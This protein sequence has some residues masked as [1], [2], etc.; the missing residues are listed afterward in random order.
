[1]YPYT[2]KG[3]V[4]LAP[5]EFR[6]N[7]LFIV[8]EKDM[9]SVFSTPYMVGMTYSDFFAENLKKILPTDETVSYVRHNMEYEDAVRYVR[10]HFARYYSNETL[11]INFAI[12]VHQPIY[13][14]EVKSEN[15]AID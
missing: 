1:M 12:R 15:K 14:H 7:K 10:S 5:K 4:F 11:Y 3:K 6:L 13:L 8:K 2:P 9:Y